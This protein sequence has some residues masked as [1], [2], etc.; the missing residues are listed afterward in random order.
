MAFYNP[1]TGV[2]MYR[3]PKR[4]GSIFKSSV[5]YIPNLLWTLLRLDF[6]KEVGKVKVVNTPDTLEWEFN[7]QTGHLTVNDTLSQGTERAF[8]YNGTIGHVEADT[9]SI[10]L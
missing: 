3:I 5:N 7:S 2:R 9:D 4:I 10:L 6:V 8:S 1:T